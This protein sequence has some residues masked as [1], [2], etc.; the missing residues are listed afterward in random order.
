[1]ATNPV[2]PKDHIKSCLLQSGVEEN[3]AED[4]TNNV[5][6]TLNKET[7]RLCS[8]E[9]TPDKK[10]EFTEKI[11]AAQS[12]SDLETLVTQQYSQL[13]LQQ[14]TQKALTNTFLRMANILTS[15]LSRDQ[16]AK[17][18]LLVAKTSESPLQ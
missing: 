7:L 17:F 3:L 4:I 1:M 14:I 12:F 2:N 10:T 5:L 11:N 16:L 15:K 18:Q 6:S 8:E 13:N 9:L